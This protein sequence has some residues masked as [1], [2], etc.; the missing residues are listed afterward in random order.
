MP[1][2]RFEDRRDE[3]DAGQQG[4]DAGDLQRPEVVVD[5]DA[6]RELRLTERWV[7]DPAGLANS[8]TASEMFV[9][10]MPEQLTE[11]TSNV[12]V[13]ADIRRTEKLQRDH[14]IHQRITNGIAMKKIMIVPMPRRS[15]RRN[16]PAADNPAHPRPRRPAE[17]AS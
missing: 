7:R 12:S 11:P 2:P 17:R 5:A 1:C 3:I 9:E 10:R 6:G 8:P 15:G 4:A 14:E 13:A 16:A